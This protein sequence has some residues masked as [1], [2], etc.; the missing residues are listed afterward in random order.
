MSHSND[1]ALMTLAELAAAI[2]GRLLSSREAT[3]A[4]LG[5]IA[6]W[7]PVL[8]AFIA[9]EPE[10]ALQAADAADARIAEGR[11]IGP[12]DGV[13]FAHK[14]MFLSLIHI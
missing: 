8:N 6:E 9:I 1:P 2:A 11:A 5:R 7:Q 10:D 13:P 12:F 3:Q 14:D 4:C